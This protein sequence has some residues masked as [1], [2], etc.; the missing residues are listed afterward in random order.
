MAASMG[1]ATKLMDKGHDIG[2]Y[3][4]HLWFVAEQAALGRFRP[5]CILAYDQS[6]RDKAAAKG[7]EVFNYGD[8]ENFYRHLGSAAFSIKNEN[9][10]KTFPG[11]RYPES[12]AKSSEIKELKICGM[13][14]HSVCP[15]GLSCFCYCSV[16]YGTRHLLMFT[17]N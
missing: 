7:L 16:I 10:I 17:N 15:Y 1:L 11:N 13:Y 14:N 8:G 12:K 5:E 6:V 2:G 9:K 4:N 3:L